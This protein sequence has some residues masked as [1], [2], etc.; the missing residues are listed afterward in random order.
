MA[1]IYDDVELA[2]KFVSGRGSSLAVGHATAISS[3]SSGLETRIPQMSSALR[4]YSIPRTLSP[5]DFQELTIFAHARQG[6]LRAFK[7][8]DPFDF[9]TASDHRS[10]HA[11]TDVRIGTG[12]G[13][14]T[15][16]QMCKRY[17]AG[18]P[19]ETVRALTNINSYT[20]AVDESTLTEPGGYTM[21]ATT[22]VVTLTSAPQVGEIVEAGCSFYVPVRFDE[23]TDEWL[24]LS[25]DAYESTTV[26]PGLIEEKSTATGIEFPMTGTNATS[27]FVGNSHVQ[28]EFRHGTYLLFVPSSGISVFLPDIGADTGSVVQSYPRAYGWQFHLNNGG[29]GTI[30]VYARDRST[31]AIGSI[32]TITA[33]QTKVATALEEWTLAQ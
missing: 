23:A 27:A 19:W 25:H 29:T 11:V 5:A 2:A 16:F 14:T 24:G 22:G 4:R 28:V 20:V 9:T 33:Y 31:G 26:S 3:T 10:A 32:G 15:T 7:I 12:D 8:T 13:S 30:T 17:D 1:T 21:N 6:S 18:T